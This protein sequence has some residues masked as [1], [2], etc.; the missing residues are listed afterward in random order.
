MIVRLRPW[1]LALVL[2]SLLLVRMSP[3]AQAGVPRHPERT[4]HVHIQRS[5]PP[6]NGVVADVIA[7]ALPEGLASAEPIGSRIPA[8][9]VDQSSQSWPSCRVRAPHG[10]VILAAGYTCRVIAPVPGRALALW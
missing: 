3:P 1:L 4:T 6:R 9:G 2:A 7:S 10:A 5:S 8:A